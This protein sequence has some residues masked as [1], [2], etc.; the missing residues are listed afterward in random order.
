MGG[1]NGRTLLF[2]SAALG[3]AVPRLCAAPPV[4]DLVPMPKI[5]RPVGRVHNLSGKLIFV[6]KGNRQCEI[7]ADEIAARIGSSGGQPGAIVSAAAASAPGIYVLP[8]SNPIAKSLATSLSLKITPSDPGPQGYVIQTTPAQVVVIGSDNIGTLYGAMTLRQMIQP[9]QGKAVIASAYVY[10]RPDYRYRANI[11]FRKA[12]RGW[13]WGEKNRLATYKAGLDTMA[14]FK[15]NLLSG[16]KTPDP[17]AMGPAARNLLKEINA[18]ASDRGICSIIWLGTNVANGRYDKGK[19]FDNW[20]CVFS[21][22]KGKRYYCWARDDLARKNIERW[23]DLIKECHFRIL[24]LHPKDGGGIADPEIWSKRC[25]LCR[26]RFADDRWKASVRQFNLWAR[27]MKSRVPDLIISSPIYPYVASYASYERI[28]G[29]PKAVWRKNSVDYWANLNGH[30]DR[31]VIPMTWAAQRSLMDKYRA[32]FSGRPICIYAHSIVPLVYF[33][34]WNRNCKTN[35]YGH[36]DDIFYTASGGY[37]PDRWLNR[38]NACEYAWNTLAPGH[39]RFTGLYYDAEREHTEPKEIMEEWVPRACRAFYGKEV[40]DLVTPVYTA[41]VQPFYIMT[42]GRA[43]ALANKLRRKPLAAVDPTKKA[44]QTLGKAVAPDIVDSAERMAFQ[45][46]ATKQAMDALAEAFPRFDKVERYPRKVL[47]YHYK[48]MPLW[49]LTARA[50]HACY[51]ARRL[52]REGKPCTDVLKKALADFD[53][54]LAHAKR[55]LD[56]TSDMRAL[57]RRGPLHPR[58]RTFRPKPEKV[59]EL[60]NQQLASAAVVLKPRRP[61]L[62]IK[63][64]IHKG[65]GQNGT[66]AFFEQFRNVKADVIES[67]SP[68]VLERYDCLFMLQNKLIKHDEYFHNLPRF[69]KEGGRGI[70]FQHDMCGRGRGAFGKKTPFPE[71]VSHVS[72][73]KDARDIFVKFM[74]PV[75]PGLKHG[76]KVRHMYYDHLFPKPGPNGKVVMENDD[77]E[78][79]VVV[80]TAGLG[81]VV[82]DGNVNLTAHDKDELL[83]G[84]N[85]VIARGAVEWFT[86]VKLEKK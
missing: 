82:F 14:R 25:P 27:I 56:E 81:K 80:G 64:A 2:L 60:L 66:K 74:H 86:D 71:I 37:G 46:Q 3:F 28:P 83:T 55:L 63:I 10:D 31:S 35:Y 20:D 62:I 1:I 15:L 6:E 34:T 40:G 7:A 17:R 51:L 52:Q 4:P 19:E 77:G 48:H 21:P 85:A 12:I 54:D 58:N 42:P 84:F 50:R 43:I 38:I 73:R 59:R 65:L 67:L 23:A 41:G 47:M 32:C 45:V 9:G 13:G 8:I 30:M 79:V 69:V 49:H 57:D 33:G 11:H 76:Q 72:G 53:H 44:E 24:F 78:P 39:E 75:A 29:V 61:G 22:F 26:K 18:Y 5:Y 70:V 36:P 68:V 16:Q